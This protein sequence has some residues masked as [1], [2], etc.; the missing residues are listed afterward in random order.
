[1]TD[2]ELFN[3]IVTVALISGIVFLAI[4]V[5]LFFRL[6]ILKVIGD[7]TGRSAK[8]GVKRKKNKEEVMKRREQELAVTQLKEAKANKKQK[9]SKEKTEKIT[10]E[11]TVLQNNETE[12]LTAQSTEV[13]ASQET[14]VLGYAETEVLTSPETEVLGYAETE[15]L[16]SPETEVLGEG[17]YE[18]AP[19]SSHTEQ[20]A[21]KNGITEQ[22]S[23]G[24]TEVLAES[25]ID[26][27][28]IIEDNI[29]VVNT[30]IIID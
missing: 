6:K 18:T 25:I 5:I 26:P 24:T 13:L 10:N 23:N 3:L 12:V 2:A 8:Q 15:V 27:D 16:T 29:T 20:L 22:L 19:D 1:M 30:D 7:L 28:L 17:S 4:S 14:E 11:T 9:K 21:E